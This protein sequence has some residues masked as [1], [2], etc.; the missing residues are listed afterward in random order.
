MYE[1]IESNQA[2]YHSSFLAIKELK[3]KDSLTTGQSVQT[4]VHVNCTS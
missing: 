4:L 1:H 2:W 3:N